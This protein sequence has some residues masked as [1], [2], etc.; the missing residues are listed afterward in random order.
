MERSTLDGGPRAGGSTRHLVH[1]PRSGGPAA[2]AD[3]A[4]EF[5]LAGELPTA[6][7][8]FNDGPGLFHDAQ[9]AAAMVREV[10]EV[11]GQGYFGVPA[12]R[13]GI[14]YQFG[15]D[16]SDVGAW[17]RYPGP[18]PLVVTM[19]V[20][21]EKMIDGVPRALEFRTR[22]EIDGTPAGAGSA[23][24]LFLAPVVHRSHREHSRT[25]A[26]KAAA[27]LGGVPHGGPGAQPAEVGRAHPANVLLRD[28]LTLSGHQLSVGV[29]APREWNGPAGPDHGQASAVML[30]E[31]LRQTALLT[32]RRT[33]GLEPQHSTTAVLRTHFRGYAEPDLP[34]RCTAVVQPVGED[35]LGRPLLPML[36]TLTQAGRAV[37]EATASVVEDL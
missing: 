17:R 34:L 21:P 28:P 30:L 20:R 2:P 7:P 36:M 1:R 27:E 23:K 15:L 12:D 4:Q 11:I 10:G 26:L 13:T 14:F 25:A 16:I 22:F 24:L 18:A 37:V 3:R 32:A 8:L 35:P 19:S 9:A 29:L 5:V 6:H 31:A 33:H